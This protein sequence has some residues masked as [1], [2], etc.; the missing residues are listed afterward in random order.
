M[1]FVLT[2]R[3]KETIWSLLTIDVSVVIIG[4][5]GNFLVHLEEKCQMASQ[6]ITLLY[7]LNSV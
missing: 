4:T 5:R 7:C 2:D 1:F 6:I 3:V